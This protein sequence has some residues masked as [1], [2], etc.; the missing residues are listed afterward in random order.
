MSKQDDLTPILHAL[1]DGKTRAT[2]G[3]VAE[4]IGAVPMFLMS[5]RPRDP[6]HSWVVNKESGMPTKYAEDQMHPDLL[7]N[8][9]VIQTANELATYL[10]DR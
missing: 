10:R 7:T 4:Q 6:L 1:Q 2:Y 3:A 5:G 9:S 8:S